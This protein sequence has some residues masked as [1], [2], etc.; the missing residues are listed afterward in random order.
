MANPLITLQGLDKPQGLQSAMQGIQGANAV[1]QM[2]MQNRLLAAQAQSAEMQNQRAQNEF[3]LSDMATDAI[4]IKKLLEADPTGV[5]A[6]VALDQRIKKIMDRGGDPSDTMAARDMLNSGNVQG[7]LAELEAPIQAAT[8]LG[9]IKSRSEIG[10]TRVGQYNPGDYTP[11]SWNEFVQSEYK[12]PSVLTRYETS[13]QERIG[14]DPSLA[15]RVAS[16]QQ[17]V[18][19]GEA[20]GTAQGKGEETRAQDLI[21]RGISA[22][23]STATIRRAISLLDSVGTGGFDSA[24]LRAKQIFGIESGD[25]GELSNS[26]GKAVLGQLRETFGAAFTQEEGARLERIEANFSKSPETNKRLLN[27]A[28]RIAEK[29][30]NRAMKAAEERGDTA[31]VDDI[32]DMLDFSLDMPEASQTG[33]TF[34]TSSGIKVMVE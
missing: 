6:N 11:E 24:A 33:S 22:A 31:S 34:T 7:F 21:S 13:V 10:G 2:P 18:K 20:A 14:N 16:G 27:Q 1:E 3:I 28:L 26:L 4:Q 30:A 19:A 17:V 25:E 5:Q 32:K 29:T 23:E 15:T 8:Q 12:D 9:L